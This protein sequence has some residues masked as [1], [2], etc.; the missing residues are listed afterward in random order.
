MVYLYRMIFNILH[1]S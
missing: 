1:H